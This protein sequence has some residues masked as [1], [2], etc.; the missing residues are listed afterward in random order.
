MKAVSMPRFSYQLYSSRNFPPVGAT[1]AML[2]SAGFSEVEG[3]SGALDAAG[4]ASA[5]RA[6]LD[7]H[8]LTM[9]TAHFSLDDIEKNSAGVAADAQALGVGFIVIP[10]LSPEE[11]PT[12]AA[13]WVAFG[14]R[15]ERAAQP[16]I[17]AGFTVGWHNHDFELVSVGHDMMP[18]DIIMRSA[19]SLKIELDLAWVHAAGEDPVAWIRACGDR[20]ASVHIKDR[21]KTADTSVEDGW[22]DVGAGRL[23]WPS[24]IAALKQST[25]R[26][27]IV[28]HDNPAD[29]ARFARNSIA[30]L[31]TLW[32]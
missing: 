13:G 1:L 22:A 18:L 15:L 29:D 11:R 6:M 12:D 4:G 21:S 9:P 5:L 2:A 20:L 31:Q 16:L 23:D 8:G 30:N 10:W 32:A 3:F 7:T 24:I 17:A 27:F 28:E 14:Q 19:P 26:H 25:A